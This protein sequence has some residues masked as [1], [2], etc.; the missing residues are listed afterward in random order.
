[1]EDCGVFKPLAST[2]NPL[3]LCCFYPADPTI[4]STLPSLKPPAKADHVKGLLLLAKMR[5]WPYIIVVFQGGTITALGLLQELHT[6]SAL[7]CIPIYRP[8]ETKDGHRPRISCCPFCAYTIQNDPAYLN[9]I[10]SVH[11]NANFTCGT[12]LSA[13]TPSCQQMKRHIG[14]CKGLDPPACQCRR[15][16]MRLPQPH[17]RRTQW[18]LAK[19]STHVSKHA[20]CKKK[21]H[22]SEKS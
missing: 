19:K 22:R 5:S 11:Y 2:T 14:R 21:G 15:D 17:R 13:V 9:H 6:W 7:A 16:Q 8:E 20:G 18:S 3:G 1:M 12:C 10:V 4:T